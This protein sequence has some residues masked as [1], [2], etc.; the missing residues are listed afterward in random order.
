MADGPSPLR[1]KGL[2]HVGHPGAWPVDGEDQEGNGRHLHQGHGLEGAHLQKGVQ[3]PRQAQD[4]GGQ[5]HL[6][7]ALPFHL[8]QHPEGLRAKL[9][10][11]P[12]VGK[13][14]T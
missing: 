14:S 4:P 6:G 10:L 9:H 1:V 12:P 11:L 7:D 2:V 5:K 13:R 8:G 3:D